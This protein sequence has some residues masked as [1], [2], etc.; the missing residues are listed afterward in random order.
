MSILAYN[1]GCV[2]GKCRLHC[3][4]ERVLGVRLFFFLNC[5]VIVDVGFCL[6]VNITL[7][8]F[9]DDNVLRWIL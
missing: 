2:V 1:G 8:S 3:G 5:F 7:G 4:S 9:C 6:H